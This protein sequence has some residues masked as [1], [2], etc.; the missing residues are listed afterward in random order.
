MQIKSDKAG[1]PIVYAMSAGLGLGLAYGV[2]R[3]FHLG[4]IAELATSACIFLILWIIFRQGR[5]SSY[6]S[7]QAWAQNELN[8]AMEVLNTAI[9][10]AESYAQAYATAISNANATASNNVTVQLPSVEEILFSQLDKEINSNAQFDAQQP[11]VSMGEQL[12]E[13]S[14]AL[15][16]STDS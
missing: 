13:E 4:I 10:K 3:S 12:S 8:V 6:S 1:T 9:A 5:K 2:V 7:A 16:A 15:R 11:R 14:Q